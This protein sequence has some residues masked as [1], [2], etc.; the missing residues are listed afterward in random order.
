MLA[1]NERSSWPGRSKEQEIQRYPTAR[2]SINCWI[3]QIDPSH[4]VSGKWFQISASICAHLRPPFSCSKRSESHLYILTSQ[5]STAF[6]STPKTSWGNAPLSSV[7]MKTCE[8]PTTSGLTLPSYHVHQPSPAVGWNIANFNTNMF[9]PNS[10]QT[11]YNIPYPNLHMFKDFLQSL[12]SLGCF[13]KINCQVQLQLLNLAWVQLLYH[14]L[15][16]S[17]ELPV[18]STGGV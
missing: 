13:N 15:Q 7:R 3:V 16:V 8:L 9:S 18:R 4:Q 12:L 2:R 17:V 11:F 14:T 10:F 6:W 1:A 5:S